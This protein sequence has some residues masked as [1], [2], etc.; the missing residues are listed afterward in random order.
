MKPILLIVALC[1][2]VIALLVA[3]D[4]VGSPLFVQA[5]ASGA[6]TQA[7]LPTKVTALKPLSTLPLASATSRPAA[8][9]TITTRLSATGALAAPTVER[10]A[11]A[12]PMQAK[13][14]SL[15]A[16][17][18]PRKQTIVNGRAY[19][20]YIPA[21][22]KLNQY[23]HYTCEFD[24]AWVILKTY[25]INVTLEDQVAKVGLDKSVEPYYKET[26]SGVQIY[27][28]D[29][30]KMYS[31]DYKQNFLARS[32]GQAMRKAFEGYGLQVTPVHDQP[33]V[34]AALRR[35][36]LIWIKTTVDFKPGRP[37]VWIKPDGTPVKTDTGAVYKTVLG[38]DHA[39]VIMGYNKDAVVIRDVLGPTSTNA[40]RK[41]EYEVPWAKFLAMWSLQ[42]YDGIAV[43]PPA[44]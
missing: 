20:A 26:A 42:S 29:I 3:Y 27:G 39:L 21:A 43:A 30:S 35:G 12:A 11:V 17:Q 33:S 13:A 1:I 32:S 4:K 24:A 28:G 34:E 25:G 15:P 18:T 38:N 22:T 36:E 7:S 16:A 14:T 40:N 19:D 44:K 2:G 31:G 37:A 6:S 9:P 8:T 23:F 10:T 41:Y 5:G